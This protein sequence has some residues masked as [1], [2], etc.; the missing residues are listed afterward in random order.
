MHW[1]FPETIAIPASFTAMVGGHPLVAERLWHSGLHTQ[2]EVKQFLDPQYYLPASPFEFPGM[3]QAV[4]I[5]LDAISSRSPILIWGDFDVD[6]QTSTTLLVSALRQCGANVTY[7]IP[8]REKESHGIKPSI[9]EEFIGSGIKLMITCDTGITAHEAINLAR[10]HG[11]QVIITDHHKMGA[12]LPLANAIINPNMLP[13]DHPLSSLPGVGV[14]FKFIEALNA[15]AS[16]GL[17]LDQFLDLVALGAVADVSPLKLDTR[18]LLQKGLPILRKAER[19]GLKLLYEK[20]GV[21]MTG[22][23]PEVIGFQIAP[24]LNAI[25]RLGDANPIVDLLLTD[26]EGRADVIAT[27]IEGMN[28]HRQLLVKQVLDSALKLVEEDPDVR[29]SPVIIL[30]RPDWPPGIIG[31]VASHLV[32]KYHK[33]AILMTGSDG[34]A[35]GSARSIEGIDITAAI[36]SQSALL[37]GFGGHTMAGGLSLPFEN[38]PAF[39]LGLNAIV[40]EQ[41]KGIDLTPSLEIASILDLSELSLPLIEEIERLSPFGNGNPPL[42]FVTRDLHVVSDRKVGREMEHRQIHIADEQGLTQKVLW[43][44]AGS[45]PLPEGRFD[46]AYTISSTTWRGEET[47]SLTWIDAHLPG[48]GEVSSLKPVLVDHRSTPSPLAELQELLTATPGLEICAEGRTIPGIET[49]DRFQLQPAPALAIWHVP[50]SSS[51]LHAMITTVEPGTIHVFAQPSAVLNLPA[52]LQTTT[53]MLKYAVNQRAGSFSRQSLATATALPMDLVNQALLWLSAKGIYRF[54]N[55]AGEISLALL[56][57]IP[58][59]GALPRVKVDLE[60]SWNE[61]RSFHD[62]FTSHPLDQLFS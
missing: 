42:T 22:I 27:Q 1:T 37:H 5:A 46:L 52:L 7:H 59:P 51:V 13:L 24:R 12:S 57:G 15:Q 36:G 29:R 17:D 19:L 16:C 32:D 62:F 3:Q 21:E 60:H 44:N 10:A 55:L 9:L 14:A 20:A 56:P 38:L 35:R 49:H 45:E 6:G 4:D 28:H 61:Y 25:G 50:P 31:I 33:P 18:Y 43:W 23:T 53:G 41:V 11:V 40:T 8:I 58:D 34:I 54:E 39:T 26:D 47:V 30:H 48:P 2:E